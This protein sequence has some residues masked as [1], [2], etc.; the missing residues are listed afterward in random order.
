[1]LEALKLFNGLCSHY[2][3]SVFSPCLLRVLPN[4]GTNRFIWDGNYISFKQ[5]AHHQITMEGWANMNHVVSTSRTWARQRQNGPIRQCQIILRA[6]LSFVSTMRFLP[7]SICFLSP[8]WLMGSLVEYHVNV[9]PVRVACS[10]SALSS[11]KQRQRETQE[12]YINWR[13]SC[14][15]VLFIVFKHAEMAESW[16]DIIFKCFYTVYTRIWYDETVPS[17]KRYRCLLWIK[18]CWQQGNYYNQVIDSRQEAHVQI[19]P[20]MSPVAVETGVLDIH[21][22]AKRSSCINN[23]VIFI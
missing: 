23:A 7:V 18:D 14:W 20:A 3:V 5:W 1:M 16:P 10:G 13:V 17:Y 11:S 21:L 2:P 8:C 9:S 4:G 19:Y 22:P 15:A 6:C 12:R